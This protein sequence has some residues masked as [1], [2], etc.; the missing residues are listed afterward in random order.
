MDNYKIEIFDSFSEKLE[1]CWK[2]FEK[3]S[4]H[5]IFQT[6]KWQKLWLEK[7]LEYEKKITNC[8]TL[9]YENNELI[10]I[11]PFNIKNY[12]NIKILSWSGFPFSDYNAPLISKK[13]QFKK[14]DFKIIWNKI[15]NKI[16]SID[17]IILDNQ[18][19]NIIDQ[20]NPFFIFL[21]NKINNVFFGIEYDKNFKIKKKELDN[22]RYQTNRLNT[23]GKLTFKVAKSIEEKKKIID[24]IIHNKSKQYKNTKAWN[25][26]K[27]K[28]YLDFFI[29]S[30][31]VIDQKSYITYLEFDGKVIAA[32]SGYTYQKISYYLFPVYDNEFKR[33]SP[34]KILLKYIIDDAENN[35]FD[36]FDLTI[37]SENYKKDYSNRKLN[38]ALFLKSKSLKGFIYIF[39]VKIK[40]IIKKNFRK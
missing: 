2:E 17:C 34:G 40:L 33:Y 19:E 16:K 20:K 7:Q 8:T 6:F 11:M 23:L 30:N 12:L 37:G 13:K 32:H 24:F 29:S 15:L 28:I 4:F 31:L 35:L 26:F 36:Y 14:D 22:I 10:M 39:L 1:I 21:K 27:E 3:D 9:V 38:S 18:P 5:Y 25:I